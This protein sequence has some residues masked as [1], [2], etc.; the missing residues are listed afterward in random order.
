M[1]IKEMQIKILT[2]LDHYIDE[3]GLFMN[4]FY[5]RTEKEVLENIEK[6]REVYPKVF[7]AFTSSCVVSK[8]FEKKIIKENKFKIEDESKIMK[9]IK[10][11]D[12]PMMP[13][14]NEL[15]EFCL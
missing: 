10:D 1:G 11:H 2:G 14:Y 9:A 12:I 8:A 13:N 4:M 3:E 5:K 7:G 6:A 15:K